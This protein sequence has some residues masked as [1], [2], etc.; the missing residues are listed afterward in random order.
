MTASADG[1][2]DDK[3]RRNVPHI[4][5]DSASGSVEDDEPA[6]TSSDG[7]R[8]QKRKSS[9]EPSPSSSTTSTEGEPLSTPSRSSSTH[10]ALTTPVDQS[11]LEKLE[12]ALSY[13]RDGD[14]TSKLIGL[15]QLRSIVVGNPGLRNNQELIANCWVAI[16][17]RFLYRLLRA[18]D[19]KGDRTLDRDYI[20]GVAVAIINIFPCLLLGSSD[21]SPKSLDQIPKLLAA[22]KTSPPDTNAQILEILVMANAFLGPAVLLAAKDWSILWELA[23]KHGIVLQLI[24]L[25]YDAAHKAIPVR[26]G[27]LPKL[28]E[29]I[30][31]LAT[32]FRDTADKTPFFDCVLKLVSYIPRVSTTQVEASMNIIAAPWLSAITQLLLESTTINRVPDRPSMTGAAVLLA[33]SLLKT[34]PAKFPML[35]FASELVDP[36]NR[37]SLSFQ[38]VELRLNRLYR[39][40]S[41]FIQGSRGLEH[42][43]EDLTSC[44]E[45]VSAFVEFYVERQEADPTSEYLYAQDLVE[46]LKQSLLNVCRGTLMYLCTRYDSTVAQT[47]PSEMALP[48]NEVDVTVESASS[49]RRMVRDSLTTAQLRMLAL[50]LMVDEK[51]AAALR[52]PAGVE[53]LHVILGFYSEGNDIRDSSLTIMAEITCDPHGVDNFHHSAGWQILF[54]DLES[55]MELSS[56]PEQS[57]SNALRIM[58][59]LNNVASC[60]IKRGAVEEHWMD[61]IRRACKLDPE[62]SVRALDIR[63][64]FAAV[65]VYIYGKSL[66]QGLGGKAELLEQL[67]EVV[68]RLHGVRHRLAGAVLSIMELEEALRALRFLK[69]NGARTMV[70]RLPWR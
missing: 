60:D 12:P 51:N 34:F 18:T 29:T 27:S 65:A 40:I 9:I 36:V 53:I 44:Y 11:L 22:L 47:A 59:I 66:L 38:F 45:I 28:D 61:V 33:A 14:D 20:I 19:Y 64:H 30:S 31:G 37:A 42:M 39:G 16:P 49:P 23:V 70:L 21:N 55:I 7:E 69:R 56:P 63:Y 67:L 8:S 3:E 68:K 4:V 15:S 1:S 5:V 54:K 35:L 62:V 52:S 43:S 17:Q 58:N 48:C 57:Q 25:T 46:Q 6:V 41:S 24:Q 13:L 26:S 10:S 50:W 32:A 2:P